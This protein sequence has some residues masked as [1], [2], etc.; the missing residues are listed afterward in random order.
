ME[1]ITERGAKT[2]ELLLRQYRQYPALQSEDVFKYLFQST[3]GCGHLVSDAETAAEGIRCERAAC[4]TARQGVEELDGAY[5]RVHLGCPDSGLAPETLAKLFC[6]SS[7]KEVGGRDALLAKLKVAQGMVKN[8][9]LPL[10]AEEFE[11]VLAAWS[12]A[13]YPAL[14]HSRA[15]ASAYHPAYRVIAKEYLPFLPLLAAIDG[16]LK[17]GTA[18]VAIEGGAAAG[19]TTLASLLQELYDGNVFHTDDFFLRP[20]QRT[21]SRL[22]E[23]GGNLD[24]ER[25]AS[26]VLLPLK[27]HREVCYRRYDCSLGALGEPITVPPRRL[28]VIEGVYSMHPAFG[29]YYDLSV[30]LDITPDHQRGRIKK[31]NAPELAARF[32][33]EWIPLELRYFRELGIK[34]AAELVVPV[35]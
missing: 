8:G 29:K 31:R 6:L 7:L 22:A 28:T 4:K 24:R 3:F 19:K 17:R 27:E 21:S 14:H 32:F 5:S 12:A 26:E 30:F 11:R 35:E 34:N 33:A 1:A 9:E 15:F 20:E 13:G 16:L 10:D 23:V 2:R 25:F 18:V